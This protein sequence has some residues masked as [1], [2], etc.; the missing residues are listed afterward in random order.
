[1]VGRML[2]HG[3]GTEKNVDKALE[4]LED[5]VEHWHT[6]AAREI[7]D[8][9]MNEP[10]YWNHTKVRSWAFRIVSEG[11]GS[12][13]DVVA[14]LYYEGVVFE[15]DE[16]K[17][18]ST[19]ELGAIYGNHE[20]MHR[21]AEHL[22]ENGPDHDAERAEELERGAA[23][24]G[25]AGAQY[26]LYRLYRSSDPDE[27]AYWLRRSAMG[28]E[29]SAMTDLAEEYATGGIV[30]V[31]NSM[32]VKWYSK[33]YEKDPL[34]QD[35]LEEMIA[36]LDPFEEPDYEDVD[37]LKKMAIEDDDIESFSPVGDH[38]MDRDNE[39]FDVNIATRWYTRGAKMGCTSCK[40]K[41]GIIMYCGIGRDADEKG[42]LRYI[43]D[44]AFD[45]HPQAQYLM[46][47]YYRRGKAVRKDLKMARR[48]FDRAA[49]LGSEDAARKLEEMEPTEEDSNEGLSALF[50][51]EDEEA[52]I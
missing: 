26:G 9:Y 12:A 39:D 33:A 31:S 2:R 15:Y 6:R 7:V 49:F 24:G 42:A 27:A 45:R 40:E 1:M 4:F 18:L 11:Y 8:I 50:G 19:L 28:G 3:I 51:S 13:M 37:M 44:A 5:A 25:H 32:A 22:W 48:W 23:E 35:K 10:G 46:G 47:I 20:C 14:D 29:L 30:H 36:M 34:V 43:E 16:E 41:L 21:F 52:E 17:Y 38:Y